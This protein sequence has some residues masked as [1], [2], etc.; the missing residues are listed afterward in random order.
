M[1]ISSLR[2]FFYACAHFTIFMLL[3]KLVFRPPNVCL[4]NDY[5]FSVLGYSASILLQHS[6]QVFFNVYALMKRFL[7]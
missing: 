2:E 4:F 6:F 5:S 1:R 7:H 3:L